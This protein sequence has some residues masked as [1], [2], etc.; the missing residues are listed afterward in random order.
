MIDLNFI[1]KYPEKFSELMQQRNVNVSIEKIFKLDKNKKLKISEL[2]NLQTERNSISK[3][4][5]VYKKDKKETIDLEKKVTDIKIT[6]VD[7][8]K[9]LKVIEEELNEIIL[10]LPNI[11]DED[12]PVGENES[13]NKEILK[14]FT[15][16]DFKFNP[17]SHDILGK[18]LNKMMDFD[19]GALI[20]GARF[21]VLKSDLALLERALIN[22]MLDLHIHKH[23][24]TEVSTPH[25]VKKD[26]LIGTGQL[27][28]FEDDLFKVGDDKWLIPTAEVTLTNFF[29]DR[30]LNQKDLPIRLVA[31]SSC[32]R[33]EA[34][35]AGQDTKGMIRL[36]EFKKVELV[37]LVEKN[38]SDEEL[39]RL[40]KSA[41]KVLDLLELPYRVVKLCT[42][43][44]G[45]SACKT[46]DIE[47]WLPSQK[48]YREISS[49]SNCRDFQARRM[50]TKYKDS[51]G[52][53]EFVHTL[54]GSGLAI[55][56]TLLAILENYQIDDNI[57]KVP[58]ILVDYMNG[59]K[60][61]STK[62]G[63]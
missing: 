9:S 40:L 7:L 29:K 22:F 8:E 48:K 10:R 13:Y 51:K 44:M 15:P 16:I 24:Y 30:I 21:V 2:Q 42:G 47:V 59:K 25:I 5:G 34:G 37:S 1:K 38:K 32:Y 56:R 49:C 4:I 27:P 63:Q 60:E 62:N 36:H 31:Q 28:K 58:N 46:Y 20:S 23:N 55:G 54:N 18:N 17:V 33:S 11:P 35:S 12:V 61:I 19:L 6:T 3:L 45:F 26:T 14:K 50:K 53:K 57:I 39:E 43:D 52:N 41:S